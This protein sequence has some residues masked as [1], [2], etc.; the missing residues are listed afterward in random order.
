MFNI[1]DNDYTKRSIKIFILATI[2]F[3]ITFVLAII[4]TPSLATLKN[5]GSGTPSKLSEARGLKKVW[6]YIINNG[7][8]TPLQMLTI[9]MIPIPFLYFANLISTI[10]ITGILFGFAVHLDVYKGSIM[11][12]SS[13]PHTIIEILAMCFVISSLYKLNQAIIRKIGNLFRKNKKERFSLKLAIINL[14]KI[15]V[16]IALPLYIIAAFIETY[17]PSFIENL[18]H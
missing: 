4:F 12:L 10:I 11:V 7:F 5:L 9:A 13:M 14:F 6:E 16:F 17:F 15:Y 1:R 18:F 8:R 3:I 2:I